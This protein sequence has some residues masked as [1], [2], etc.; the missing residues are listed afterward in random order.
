MVEVRVT[1]KAYLDIS[2]IGDF[3]SRDSEKY[4]KATIQSFFEAIKYLEEFPEL[5]RIVPEVKIKSIREIILGNYRIINWIISK[6]RVDVIAIHHSAPSFNS[7][8]Y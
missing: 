3:I 1:E 6:K 7:E 4:A 5:G 8:T 2:A